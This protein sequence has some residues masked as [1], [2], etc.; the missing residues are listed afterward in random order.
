MQITF[1]LCTLTSFMLS[2]INTSAPSTDARSSGVSVNTLKTWDTPLCCCGVCAVWR[3]L[4]G[5][6][7]CCCTAS[8]DSGCSWTVQILSVQTGDWWQ[9]VG[10]WS[11]S[12]SP[13]PWSPV[14]LEDSER[15]HAG[16]AGTVKRCRSA[17]LAQSH[18]TFW[19]LWHWLERCSYSERITEVKHCN[20]TFTTPITWKIRFCSCCWFLTHIRWSVF[21][22]RSSLAHFINSLRFFDSS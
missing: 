13:P 8:L 14:C 4:A 7:W 18:Q 6:T 15:F 11:R 21:Q 19:V 5:L 9:A 12:R 2:C 17:A 3:V 22:S 16:H 1:H 10:G 20:K